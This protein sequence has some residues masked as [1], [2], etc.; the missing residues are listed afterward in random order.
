MLADV[1]SLIGTILWPAVVLVA[2]ALFRR[3]ISKLLGSDNVTVKGPGGFE[4]S[5]SSR[6]QAATALTKASE[7]PTATTL[8]RA[9]ALSQ[10]DV[11]ARTMQEIGQRA[12]ALWVDDQPANNVYEAEALE[13]VG[14]DVELSTSTADA[15]ARVQRNPPYDVIISDM[16]RADDEQAGYD[17]LD[18]LRS[19]GD[20]TPVVIYAG[21]RSAEHFNEAVRRG[22]E[23]S[24]NQPQELVGLVLR[25]VRRRRDAAASNRS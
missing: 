1:T 23:G 22:A 4:L 20:L 24:T 9:E 2:L 8:G 10:V 12:R 25:A 21:S 7:K 18:A 13:A 11:A 5:A 3:P 16:V 17:L 19:A 14:I 6:E 15:L